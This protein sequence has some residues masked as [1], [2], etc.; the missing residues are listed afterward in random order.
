MPERDSK[1]AALLCLPNSGFMPRVVYVGAAPIAGLRER[2]G[3][4]APEVRSLVEEQR[5]ESGRQPHLPAPAL[6][7]RGRASVRGLG[8]FI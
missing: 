7:N 3:R 6:V 1:S 2:P 5:F 4:A 8:L